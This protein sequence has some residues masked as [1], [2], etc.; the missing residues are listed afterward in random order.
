MG[1]QPQ[2]SIKANGKEVAE[3]LRDRLVEVRVSLKTGLQSD[4]CYVRFDNLGTAP[5][6][7]PKATDIVEIAMGYKNGAADKSAKLS[8]LG[9]FEVGEYSVS[10]PVRSLELF[11]NKMLWHTGLKTPKQKSWP[12]DPS[13]PQKLGDLVSDIAAEHGL[14]P[15]VGP[16]FTSIELPHIEQSESDLQ[17]L[18]KLAEQ[19][20]AVLKIAQDKLVFMARGTGKSLS[21]KPLKE[22]EI[23]VGQL[24]SWHYMQDAYRKVGEVKAYFYDQNEAKRKQVKAGKGAPATILPYVY[25]DEAYATQAAT[26]KHN[27][28]NRSAKSM[29]AKVIGDPAIGAGAVVKIVNTQTT[30]DGKWY[31]SEVE[32][33]INGE[34]FASY[35][36]CEQIAS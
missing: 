22:V 4:T 21:G 5:I 30:V 35:L 15:K 29:R 2:Y 25:A 34:G 16:D 28:L 12:D 3:R 24:L 20:D 31:V 8:P 6:Q 1:L 7:E 36:L 18:T 13:T 23:D 32:H 14:D 26:A 27:R 11:G 10:G 19:Y 33:C 17:L 9:A